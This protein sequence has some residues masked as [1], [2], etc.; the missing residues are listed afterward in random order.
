VTG[1][2]VGA[3][4]VVEAADHLTGRRPRPGASL[5]RRGKGQKEEDGCQS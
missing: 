4:P 1:R 2:R 5:R 3:A